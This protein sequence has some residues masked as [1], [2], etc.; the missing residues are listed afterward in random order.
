MTWWGPEP[1]SI[2]SLQN[3]MSHFKVASKLSQDRNTNLDWERKEI[4]KRFRKK[5]LKILLRNWGEL[6]FLVPFSS[7]IR[8][9]ALPWS[10]FLPLFSTT[11]TAD[12][13]KE[14][15]FFISVLLRRKDQT[16]HFQDSWTIIE[17]VISPWKCNFSRNI[18][19]LKIYLV[20]RVC[21]VWKNILAAPERI[22]VALVES[23]PQRKE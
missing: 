23:S 9:Q 18:C 20:S 7:P 5:V 8:E 10:P 19:V 1:G 12:S 2:A 14:Y 11:F 15:Y 17:R 16:S 4:L 21:I 22:S 6:A 13:D 3:R